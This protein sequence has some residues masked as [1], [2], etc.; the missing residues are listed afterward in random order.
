MGHHA[1][2]G[3]F[4]SVSFV[5]DGI[6]FTVESA[7]AP[8]AVPSA[9][10]DDNVVVIT[11]NTT[12][13]TAAN[14]D[15]VVHASAFWGAA[16]NISFIPTNPPRLEFETGDLG[17]VTVTFSS[18]ATLMPGKEVALQFHLTTEPLVFWLTCGPPH[19]NPDFSSASKIIETQ[20]TSV[21]ADIQ[22]AA[23]L[24]KSQ[25]DT[26]DAMSSVIAWNVNFDPRVAVT[27][28]VSRTFEAGFDFIFFDVGFALCSRLHPK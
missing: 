9:E 12:Q 26:V 19:V 24:S 16:A 23:T 5:K 17:I 18:S 8:P 4:A 10:S 22:S 28:P 1:Y 11:T 20:R 13:D 3:S 25:F 27:A 15:V 21:I 7:T 6:N 14:L 2:D